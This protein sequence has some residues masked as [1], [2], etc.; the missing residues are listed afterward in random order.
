MI[1]GRQSKETPGFFRRVLLCPETQLPHWAL[2]EIKEFLTLPEQSFIIIG[3]GRLPRRA[4]FILRKDRLLPPNIFRNPKRLRTASNTYDRVPKPKGWT[5]ITVL[6][7]VKF[8]RQPLWPEHL[9]T[10]H[11]FYFLLRLSVTRFSISNRTK[12]CGRNIK[13][14]HFF[15]SQAVFWKKSKNYGQP[16]RKQSIL[17]IR[18]KWFINTFLSHKKSLCIVLPT[19]SFSKS[20]I[21]SR[22]WINPEVF[23]YNFFR[24]G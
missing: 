14:L 23:P 21:L 9:K 8:T 22:H 11:F 19:S 20:E 6:H 10:F 13:Y 4:A 7:S 15:K 24:G 18:V 3:P 5:D 2:Q 17:S 1:S 12:S 16:S